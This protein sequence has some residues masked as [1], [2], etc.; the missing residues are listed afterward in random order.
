MS[1]ADD[2][3][4]LPAFIATQ[5]LAELLCVLRLGNAE[6]DEAEIIAAQRV[7]QRCGR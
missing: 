5:L 1:S 7:G 4:E 6:D 3:L 2:R